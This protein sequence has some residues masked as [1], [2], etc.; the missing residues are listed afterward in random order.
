MSGTV[1]EFRPGGAT[2]NDNTTTTEIVSPAV[3][4]TGSGTPLPAPVVL[5]VDRVAPQQTV[6]A[7]DPLNVEYDQAISDPATDAI[8][9]YESLEGMRVGVRDAEVGGPHR[10]VR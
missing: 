9:F 7:G 4:T 2:G 10:V 6:E 1:T 3:T 5:G 8:D